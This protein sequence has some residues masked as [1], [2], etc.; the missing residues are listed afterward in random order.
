MVLEERTSSRLLALIM[1]N[2][3]RG[4]NCISAP[5]GH[6]PPQLPHCRQWTTRSPP[7]VFSITSCRKGEPRTC[8]ATSIIEDFLWLHFI[9]RSAENRVSKFSPLHKSRRVCCLLRPVRMRI[10]TGTTC[11][12]WTTRT[13]PNWSFAAQGG[14]PGPVWLGCR[15]AVEGTPRKFRIGPG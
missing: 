5:L 13:G 6:E 9:Q 1:A 12:R 11:V 14:R 2:R 15:D 4:V 8:L 3:V 7:G 10:G